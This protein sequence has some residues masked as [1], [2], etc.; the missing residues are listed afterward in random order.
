MEQRIAGQSFGFEF[1]FASITRKQIQL[2]RRLAQL[3]F[4]DAHD[5]SIETPISRLGDFNLTESPK[6]IKRRLQRG[7]TGA[8]LVSPVFTEQNPLDIFKLVTNWAATKGETP[9]NERCGIHYHISLTYDI[10]TLRKIVS[11]ASHLEDVFF[12]VGGMGYEF[13]GQS[14]D[15]IFCRPTTKKGPIC[16]KQGRWVRPTFNLN[17]LINARTTSAF[18][19]RYGDTERLGGIRYVPVRYHWYNLYSLHSQGSLE[20]R[21]FNS[22]LNPH[23]MYAA[24]ELCKAFSNY[25]MKEKL[26]KIRRLRINSVYDNRSKEEIIN[27]L[28]LFADEVGLDAMVLILLEDIINQT[29]EIRLNNEY[30]LTHLR[31]PPNMWVESTYKTKTTGQDAKMPHFVDIHNFERRNEN[32][33]EIHHEEL[34]RDVLPQPQGLVVREVGN[35]VINL[36]NEIEGDWDEDEDGN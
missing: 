32:P 5:A 4:T 26:S 24:L 8:E 29:P 12:Y 13:R 31:T 6:E 34:E 1:E 9:E 15:S 19:T 17:D 30:V 28:K 10:S 27:T 11:L 14:N 3:N 23:Y 7:H 35:A 20:F 25:V 18:W 36:N 22:T 2:S 16:V 21:I 33:D